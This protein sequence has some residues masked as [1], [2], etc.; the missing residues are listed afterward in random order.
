MLSLFEPGFAIVRT[1]FEFLL[2]FLVVLGAL[3]A[4]FLLLCSCW[5]AYFR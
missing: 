1:I 3:I 2:P 5:W 4:V